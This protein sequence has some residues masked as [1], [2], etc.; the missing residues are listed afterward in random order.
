MQAPETQFTR[1]GE[2]RIAYQVFG[3]GPPDLLIAASA[4]AMDLRWDWPPYAYFMRRLASFSRVILF[5]RRGSGA[6]DPVS[7]HGASIW[8]D[9]ADDARAVLDAVGSEHAVVLGG[10]DSGPTV[11]L[12]A[13]TEPERTQ[14]LILYATSARFVATADYPFGFSV[15]AMR[16]S[17][18]YVREK[19][20]TEELAGTSSRAAA[21]DPEFRRWVAKHQRVSSSARQAAAAIAVLQSMD[22]RQVLPAVQA[23][24][25]ILHR[26]GFP[27]ISVDQSRDLADHLPDARLLLIEGDS[28]MPFVEPMEETLL[29]MQ[30]FVTGTRSR[31]TTTDRVLATVLFTDIVGSTERA[32]A[33]GDGRWRTLLDSHDSLVTN[34]VE[35]SGGRVVRLTGDGMLATFDGPGRAAQCAFSL[36]NA[37][38]TL[39][40]EVRAGIHTGEI[41]MRG[42][43]IGGIG[44]HVAARVMENADAGKVWVSGVVPLLMTGSDFE[45]ESRGERALK[46]VPGEWELFEIKG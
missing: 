44:V 26:K 32:A 15:E 28:V 9:W 24:A 10:F 34:V 45:F 39:A 5:D 19:W 3:E 13:A 22:V 46:G 29:E 38:R 36:R 37:L 27:M 4:D 42:D 31:A 40:V 11:I 20:G 25:L 6:S 21:E 33:E 7:R 41:E 8:E 14:S 43:D 23:P 17:E 16:A 35:Q 30:A 2:D 1:V 18:A 12:F